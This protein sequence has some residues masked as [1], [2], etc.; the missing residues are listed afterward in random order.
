MEPLTDL[1]FEDKIEPKTFEEAVGSTEALDKTGAGYSPIGQPMQSSNFVH[2]VTGWRLDSNGNLEAND[3]L[4]RGQFDIGGTQIT[5]DN[6]KDIQETLDSVYNSGG[7]TVY[8]Q[9]GEYVL[10]ADLYI[11]SGC[12]L[13]GINRDTCIINCNVDYSVLMVG[14]DEYGDG[15]ISVSNGSTTVTGSG[16]TFTDEMIG[17]TIFLEKYYYYID[18]VTDPTHLE[19]TYAYFGEDLTDSYYKIATSIS[20]TTI[21]ELSITSSNSAGLYV[22]YAINS[23]LDNINIS[24]CGTGVVAYDSYAFMFG[25]LGAYIYSN[26]RNLDYQHVYSWT[27]QN[28]VFEDAS[29][30]YGIYMENSRDATLF[31]SSI[32]TATDSNIFLKNCSEI[33]FIS[34]GISEAGNHGIEFDSL[35]SDIQLIGGLVSFNTSD[36]IHLTATSDRNT[37]NSLTISDNGGYGINITDSTCDNNQIVTPAF[38]NNTS[39]NINDLGTNTTILPNY[40]ILLEEATNPAPT[41]NTDLYDKYTA[42]DLSDNISSFTTNLLGSPKDNDSLLIKLIHTTSTLQPT[43]INYS[44]RQASSANVIINKPTDTTDGDLM[45]AFLSVAAQT[46]SSVPAGW[47]L[48]GLQTGSSNRF[49][50]YYKIASGEG[51][52]YT[53]ELGGSVNHTATISTYRSQFLDVSNPINKISNTSYVTGDN[54]CR[55]ASMTTTRNGTM[56]FYFA[57]SNQTSV[58]KPSVPTSDWVEDVNYDPSTWSQEVCSHGVQTVAGA[59]GNMDSTLD[60]TTIYKGAFAV[61]INTKISISW[62]SSFSNVGTLPLPTKIFPGETKNIHLLYDSSTSKWNTVGDNSISS[63]TTYDL[64]TASGTQ[65]I[66]HG[67][68][69]QPKKIRIRAIYNDATINSVSDGTHIKETDTCIYHL[70]VDG[71]STT[72]V[73]NSSSYIIHV[74]TSNTAYQTA[75]IIEVSENEIVVNW[76]KTG[77]P[78]GTAYILWEAE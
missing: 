22:Q 9:P 16:T 64:S 15:T 7:G 34:F 74:G 12:V 11:P 71:S 21:K 27:I 43:F 36:G 63:I 60:G 41:I 1:T 24:S 56:L 13:S 58:A 33:T 4:F 37:F 48:L 62:G 73:G 38:E 61:A 66:T 10:T 67:L 76:T 17:R 26:G 53:W 68:L 50:L 42:T 28:S 59:T 44:T 5:I 8:L 72:D 29:T 20:N 70:S 51:A 55:A 75:S 3:G 54:I 40:K 57:S 19:L 45:F 65:I 46:V 6:T 14:S 39:G 32:Y 25:S 47:N 77:T 49:Y 18:S 23:G 35:C 2:G 30:D 78:S 69:R 52:S 31:N